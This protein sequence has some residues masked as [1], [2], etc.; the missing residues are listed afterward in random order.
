MDVY[1]LLDADLGPDVSRETYLN[2]N[3]LAESAV[4]SF[5][6]SF[7]IAAIETDGVGT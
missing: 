2:D 1:A 7:G 6:H 3:T 5:R 4:E